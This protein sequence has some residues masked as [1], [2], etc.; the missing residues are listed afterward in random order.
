MVPPP[1][2]E[3]QRVHGAA[4][5]HVHPQLLALGRLLQKVHCRIGRIGGVGQGHPQ[6]GAD[7]L[8]AGV[9]IQPI[10][11]LQHPLGLGNELPSLL[12]GDHAGGAAL[13]NADAILLFQIFQGLAHV[14]LG[15]VHLFCRRRHRAP[16]HNG[17]QI[18]Q[19]RDIHSR[20]PIQKVPPLY[21]VCRRAV[22]PP[23]LTHPPQ[24]FI[25]GMM[26]LP[27]GQR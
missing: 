17:H 6:F 16:L 14:G 18:T 7:T 22:K 24:D 25:I 15:G 2:H 4:L 11:L 20:L 8:L 26:Y 23:Q 1:Q 13:K 10:H 21:Q 12:G 19:F 9:C 5:P 3:V 27:V